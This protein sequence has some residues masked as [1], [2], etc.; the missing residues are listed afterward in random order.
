MTGVKN[1]PFLHRENSCIIHAK[2][3]QMPTPNV[4]CLRHLGA[5]LLKKLDRVTKEKEHGHLVQL[6][7][8]KAGILEDGTSVPIWYSWF[9][10]A[11]PTA[12]RPSEGLIHPDSSRKAS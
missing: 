12:H 5:S 1:V 10:L 4:H 9:T 2:M 3:L 11:L 6:Q 8:L 7:L